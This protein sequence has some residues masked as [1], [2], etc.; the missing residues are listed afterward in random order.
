M[1]SDMRK[2]EGKKYWKINIFFSTG[3]EKRK[4]S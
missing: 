4:S 3:E 1:S 2:A